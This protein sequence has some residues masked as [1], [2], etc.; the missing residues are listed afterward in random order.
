MGMLYLPAMLRPGAPV[1]SFRQLPARVAGDLERRGC[2]IVRE[3][4]LV[5]GDFAGRG[6]LGWAALCQHGE[7]ASRM[8]YL[9][10]SGRPSMIGEPGAVRLG[11]DPESVRGIQSVHWDYVLR[12]NPGMVDRP[13]HP[14]ACV[15]EG[16]GMGSTIYCDLDGTWAPLAGA[17]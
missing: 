6:E 5:S 14:P 1:R 3:H 12:H 8:I 2:N 13:D 11:D 10:G 17:D 7:Q 15:E 4:G 16:V 9:D